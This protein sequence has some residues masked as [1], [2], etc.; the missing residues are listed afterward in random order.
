MSKLAIVYDRVTDRVFAGKASRTLKK[1]SNTPEDITGKFV[2]TVVKYITPNSIRTLP[3]NDGT[4]TLI[5]MNVVL[6]PDSIDK[7]VE[8]LQGLK[9]KLKKVEETV[10]N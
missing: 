2:S 10:D 7:A 3:K 6:E 4:I 8:K 9:E 1:W 5:L